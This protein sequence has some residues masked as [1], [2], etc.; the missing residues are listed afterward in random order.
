MSSNAQKAGR[1]GTGGG[2]VTVEM[3]EDWGERYERVDGRSMR[4]IAEADGIPESTVRDH[5]IGR[6]K[7]A[8]AQRG[9]HDVRDSED[10]EAVLDVLEDMLDRNYGDTI[11]TSS[12]RVKGFTGTELVGQKVRAVLAD[13]TEEDRTPRGLTAER[14]NPGANTARYAVTRVERGDGA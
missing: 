11:H 6:C 10:R 8:P 2:Y 3:C 12:G 1:A 7:H 4:D 14:N 13:L 5:L 9:V